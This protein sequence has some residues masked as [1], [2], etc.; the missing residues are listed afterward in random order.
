MMLQSENIGLIESIMGIDGRIPLWKYHMERLYQ[1]FRIF[2]WDTHVIKKNIYLGEIK[3]KVEGITSSRVKIRIEIARQNNI[4]VHNIKVDEITEW[5]KELEIGIS[6]KVVAP[7]LP[8]ANLKHTYRSHFEQ[9]KEEAFL[10]NWDDILLYNEQQR[11]VESTIANVFFLKDDT[12]YTPSQREGCV[13]G[14]MRKLLMEYQDSLGIKIT[15]KEVRLQD[16]K[17]A[18]EIFLTNAVRGIMPVRKFS[19]KLYNTHKTQTISQKL[20][21]LILSI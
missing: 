13:L 6:D 19:G 10:N 15:E 3:D 12:L 21:Q 17:I 4:Y 20:N 2:N 5:E 1:G 9:A 11:I 7:S 8:Y 16:G 14:I 18:D